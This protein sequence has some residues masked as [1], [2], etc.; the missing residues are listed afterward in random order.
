[1]ASPGPFAHLTTS[2]LKACAERLYAVAERDRDDAFYDEVEAVRDEMLR[3]SRG[4]PPGG[5][6]SAG[7]REPR[8]PRPGGDAAAIAIEPPEP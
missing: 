2:E 7:V 5:E 4:H 8:R 1:V 3:R 6:G